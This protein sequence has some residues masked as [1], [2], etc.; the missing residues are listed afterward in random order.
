[1]KVFNKVQTILRKR[2]SIISYTSG[3]LFN[4]FAQIVSNIIILGYVGP[5]ELGIWNSLILFQT[6]SIFLQ[7][8][9]INGL[10]RELPYYLGKNDRV[11][12]ESLASSALHF[13]LISIGLCFLIGITLF[14]I[15]LNE[16]VLFHLTFSGIL[17]ITITKFYEDYLTSTF[18]SNQAFEK[19]G[20]AY[21]YRGIF[22][23]LSI[24]LV[25]FGGY[26]GY[27]LRMVLTSFLFAIFLHQIRPIR[28]KPKFIKSNL[29]LLLKVGLPLFFLS[30]IFTASG[31]VDR[32]ILIKNTS[33]KVVGYYS[34]AL[35]TYEAFKTFP[36]SL[37]NYIYPKMSFDFGQNGNIKSLTTKA[38]KINL[39][40]LLI[41]L[42]IALVGY[43]ILPLLIPFLFPKYIVGV[44]S[45]QILLFAAVFSGASIGA[46][47]L[48]SMKIWRYIYVS[49]IGGAFLNVI[50]IYIGFK[51]IKD[52]IIGISFG[53]LLSQIIY[54]IFTNF[55]IFLTN[56]NERFAGKMG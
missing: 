44:P 31:T 48:W 16:S 15:N 19:L 51:L 22:L 1:M 41:M 6:Y 34:L 55:L 21:L 9:V 50:L 27:I 49:Q 54:M 40:I 7:S 36:M 46:N 35:M 18:R 56:R 29:L 4:S 33:F 10:N 8:G 47:V 2:K 43:Y 13:L 28:V 38:L 37:A 23:L 25:I 39:L 32:L 52:P 20:K 45:A 3:S 30:Y 53:V 26:Y 24:T 5:N 42:P 11:F 14:A 12:A 17:V